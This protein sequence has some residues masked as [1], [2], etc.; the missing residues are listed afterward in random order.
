MSNEWCL[1][2]L[3]KMDA[4][5]FY[6]VLMSVLEINQRSYSNGS[7]LVLSALLGLL[8]A[9]RC[10]SSY[11]N[12]FLSFLWYFE[13]EDKI[14]LVASKCLLGFSFLSNFYVL[15]FFFFSTYI[16]YIFGLIFNSF[17]FPGSNNFYLVE[18]KFYF[19]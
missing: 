7:D 12:Y 19:F 18:L 4:L 14:S 6:V 16:C 5:T 11:L 8:Q 13:L 3:R 2:I 17:S 9:R 1:I 15:F 10:I